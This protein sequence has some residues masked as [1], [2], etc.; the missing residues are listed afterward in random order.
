MEIILGIVMFTVIVLVLALMIL[1]A[2]S[3][4]VSEG[5]ITIKVNNEKE[6]TMPADGNSGIAMYPKLSAQ[7]AAYIYGQTKAIKEGKRTTGASGVMKPI[8]MNL[9]EQDMHNVAAYYNKQQ[10][11]S[12]ETS[13]KEEPELGAKIYR[14]GI[15]DKK[16]P[17]CMSCHGP[18]GAGIPGGGTDI[19]AYPRLGGQHKSYVIDQMKF[20]KSGQRANAIM[21]DIA[22]RMSDAEVNAVANFI[23]GL[24]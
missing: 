22:G 1:F 7:H 13:P 3:K 23:Q 16:V 21:A 2:K 24:H 10:P 12:G 4:L 14:G 8:V 20:Y 15:A 18:S 9:S 17:A 5:D 11:K 6:L 19:A